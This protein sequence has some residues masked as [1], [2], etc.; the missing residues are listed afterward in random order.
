M[1]WYQEIL[2]ALCRICGAEIKDH[3]RKVH[4]LKLSDEVNKVW[5]VSVLVDLPSVH[6]SFICVECQLICGKC[7]YLGG[8][9]K[10][11]TPAKTW[12]P[13][14]DKCTVCVSNLEPKRGKPSKV[15]KAKV[16]DG[17]HDMLQEQESGTDSASEEEDQIGFARV[18]SLS[19]DC[20][21]ECIE[22]IPEKDQHALL[23]ELCSSFS[24]QQMINVVKQKRAIMSS[25]KV[26]YKNPL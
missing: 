19:M 5:Q 22:R 4:A 24:D 20:L 1:E 3:K 11:A 17:E 10:T 25:G 16:D 14:S 21:S 13:R 26:T 23:M 18:Y 6:P 9:I 2:P 8:K 7:E 15:K 12:Y